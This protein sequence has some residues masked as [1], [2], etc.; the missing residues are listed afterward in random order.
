M[1]V[2]DASQLPDVS[3]SPIVV[4]TAIIVVVVLALATVTDK[5]LG[6]ITRWWY[7]LAKQRREDAAAR[8]GADYAAV[9]EQVRHLSQQ[10]TQLTRHQVADRLMHA[11]EISDMRDQIRDRDQL[12]IEH[13]RWDLLVLAELNRLG[14]QVT[15]PPPLWPTADDPTPGGPS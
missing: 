14:G 4:Y 15:A 3:G 1:P 6:P 9:L 2:S 12:A 11:A 13:Q 7:G 10:V 8:R 5:G